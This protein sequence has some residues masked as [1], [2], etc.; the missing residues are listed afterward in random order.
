MTQKWEEREGSF[1][2]GFGRGRFHGPN[3]DIEHDFVCQIVYN[4]Q[5][6]SSTHEIS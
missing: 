6:P 2:P 4:E 5:K 1:K 3:H